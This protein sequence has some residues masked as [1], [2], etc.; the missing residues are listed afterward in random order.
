M[1]GAG[2][3]ASHLG[4]PDLAIA[5]QRD[6]LDVGSMMVGIAG[7]VPVICGMTQFPPEL[8]ADADTGFGGSLNVART[9]QLY[10]RA[11]ISALHIED[12]GIFPSHSQ[13][14]MCSSD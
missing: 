2:V 3:A 13:T 14:I 8:T 12:Q 10:E 1:T 6:F 7:D 11:G 5:T 9:V 4:Q